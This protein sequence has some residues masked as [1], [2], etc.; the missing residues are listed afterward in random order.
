MQS[1]PGGQSASEE[2]LEVPNSPTSPAIDCVDDVRQLLARRAQFSET[3]RAIDAERCR[4]LREQE[5]ESTKRKLAE[6]NTVKQKKK[7]KQEEYEARKKMKRLDYESRLLKETMDSME[8]AKTLVL[9]EVKWRQ[10]VHAAVAWAKEAAARAEEAQNEADA[11]NA[12]AEEAAARL[13]RQH[14]PGRPD[15]KFR[16]GQSVFA[17]WASWFPECGL[18]EHPPGYAGKQRPLWFSSEIATVIGWRD[19]WPYAGAL[20]SGHIYLVY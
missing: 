2:E 6:L 4:V 9:A 1:Y 17:W 11:A 10:A 16:C 15:A 5:D 19:E 13:G 8:K 14:H 18:G 3:R 12:R 20:H 7:F